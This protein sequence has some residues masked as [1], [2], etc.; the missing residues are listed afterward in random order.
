MSTS[1]LRDFS[2]IPVSGPASGPELLVGDVGDPP[3]CE[4]DYIAGQLAWSPVATQAKFNLTRSDRGGGSGARTLDGEARAR[5]REALAEPGRPLDA[6]TRG[7]FE[8]RFGHDFSAVRVHSGSAAA[9]SAR[10]LNSSAYTIGNAIVLGDGRFEPHSPA[11]RYLLVHEL[12]HVAQ[13]A[14]RAGAAPAVLIRRAP[15]VP[16]VPA[17][18]PPILGATSAGGETESLY[19]YGDLEG[20]SI[21]NSPQ[22]YPRLTNCDIAKSVEEA[23]KYT[24][25]PVR[26]SVKFRYELK[27]DRAYFAKHF[28]NVATRSSGYSEFGTDQPIPVRYFRKVLTLVRGPSGSTP[29]VAGGGT[30]GG[31]VTGGGLGGGRPPLAPKPGSPTGTSAEGGAEGALS[32]AP[33]GAVQ[34]A[35]GGA[36][37]A[38]AGAAARSVLGAGLRFLTGAAIGAAIG[39]LAGLAYAAL[40]RKLIE[41]DIRYTL[42]NIPEDRR[43]KI[44]ARIDALP[45]GRKKF[46]RVTLDYTMYRST[47]GFLGPPDSYELRSVRLVNVHPGNEEIDFPSDVSE[48]PGEM[49]PVLAA[50]KV[51]VRI[52][53]TV[54]ID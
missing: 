36:E 47:L 34:G 6:G 17:A 7:A 44:Q 26:D 14:D 2:G 27:I 21:F 1:G 31:G 28:K 38:V 15:P 52:S 49:Y 39:M 54:P 42:Q 50:R 33:S 22:G 41:G 46:A 51:T 5:V 25:S 3:E 24:G 23:A 37:G 40:T 48:T 18:A 12:A 20:T 8:P 13:Q 19:H 10:A 45:A 16:P 35:E 4:A 29:P 32:K 53:Y 9:S 43:Q 11:G 30:A